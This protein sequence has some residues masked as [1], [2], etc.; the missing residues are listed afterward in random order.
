[1]KLNQLTWLVLLAGCACATPELAAQD[2]P[3]AQPESPSSPVMIT[4]PMQTPITPDEHPLSGVQTLGIGSWGLRHSVLTPSLRLVETLDSNP[5]LLSS[6]SGGYRG[7][8]SV[9]GDVQWIQYIGRDA[10]IRYSGALR[11]DTI[12]SVEGY[13]RFTNTHTASISKN[14]RFRTWGLVI[15]DEAEYSQGS[16]FGASGMGGM[17]LTGQTGL[18]GVLGGTGLQPNLLPN[19]S[20]LTGQIGRITNTA[21]AEV[22][23]HFNPRSTATLS[24]SYGLLHY[25]SSQLTDSQQASVTGGYNR[26]ITARDS[27]ALEGAFTRYFYPSSVGSM[28]TESIS[29]LYARRI[30]GRS[31]IEVGGGPEITQSSFSAGGQNIVGWQA[32]G[33]V[34]YRTRVVKLS[35]QGTHGV[36]GGAGVLDGTTT[37]TGQGTLNLVFSRDWSAA[38]HSGISRNQ[39]LN[40]AQRYDTQFAGFTL[41]RK[42][43][44]DTNLFLS[45]DFQRQTTASV[46][47]G[48]TCS[49]VGSGNIFGIGFAW[50][51][52]PISVE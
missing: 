9:A 7:F 4:E 8:S 27:I 34:Q 28:N 51:H 20:I 40:G 1:L 39:Q 32:R 44:V 49:Y 16:N 31:S 43:S 30:S 6:N 41:Y 45:Y 12:G 37:T 22:D 50:T 15:R 26:I 36:T 23:A 18:L 35:A 19:Q 13:D 3:I 47:T 42:V 11:Y 38:L 14:R 48:L 46:C 17:G 2:V 24:F 10:E 52:R 25:D 21:V 33:T 29:A 5:L